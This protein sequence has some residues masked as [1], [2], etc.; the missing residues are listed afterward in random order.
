LKVSVAS[1]CLGLPQPIA[2]EL[3][4]SATPHCLRAGDTLFEAGDVGDGCYRL[5]EGV[6]KVALVSERGEERIIS[7]LGAGA[8]VGDLAMIDQL[9]RSATVVALTD[10][11]LRFVSRANFEGCVQ[12]HPQMHRYLVT[13]LALRL[14]ETDET[15]SAL[16]FLSAK[17]RVAYALLEIAE[18][19][20]EKSGSGE[21][22]I[23]EM[24]NQKEL[25]AMAG[26]ARENT[27]RILKDWER[28][29]LVTK[30][31]R[32]YRINDKAKLEREMEWE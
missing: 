26:V 28:K 23:R 5:D 3:L 14:R 21:I 15:I 8:I 10:C 16:A 11:Q 31:S 24:L 32:S 19:L 4:A 13:L 30:L 17:G 2:S 7:I 25:A 12:K 18:S 9:P 29:N 1:Q 27:N 22:L 20:G 6:L